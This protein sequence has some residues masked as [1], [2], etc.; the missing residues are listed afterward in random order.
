MQ[1]VGGGG[2]ASFSSL[3][4][5]VLSKA[6]VDV[7]VR[8]LPV[9]LGKAILCTTE[10]V[11]FELALLVDVGLDG[12]GTCSQKRKSRWFLAGIGIV[13]RCKLLAVI[14]CLGGSEVGVNDVTVVITT[15]VVDPNHQLHSP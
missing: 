14:A 10:N 9:E 5:I 7:S 2:A 8:S 1:G 6:K 13:P 12:E 4:N 3:D 11:A 15:R